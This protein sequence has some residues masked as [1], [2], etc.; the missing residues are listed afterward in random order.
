ME[1]GRVGELRWPV[2]RRDV[3]GPWQVRG[4]SEKLLIEV[5]APPAYGLAEDEA[6]GGRVGEGEWAYGAVPAKEEHAHNAARD[7]AVDPQAPLPDL[8]DRGKRLGVLPAEQQLGRKVVEARPG[9]AQRDDEEQRLEGKGAVVASARQL[10]ARDPGADD[11]AKH[12]AHAVVAEGERPGL[13]DDRCRRTR[14]R[15]EGVEQPDQP[16]TR[17]AASA[18]PM[19]FFARIKYPLESRIVYG[20]SFRKKLLPAAWVEEIVI[21]AAGRTRGH[22]NRIHA[23]AE[24]LHISA[25]VLLGRGDVADLQPA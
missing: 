4:P 2:L 19:A 11:Y 7:P 24:I 9:E 25:E 23:S 20:G 17:G 22:Y 15:E 8:E 13:E 12:D 10:A 5:V 14:Q 18:R 21:V 16:R 1:R 3:Y 6:G